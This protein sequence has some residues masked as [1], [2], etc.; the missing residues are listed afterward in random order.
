MAIDMNV[1][2][3]L[4]SARERGVCFRSTATIGRLNF[5]M[6]PE[7]LTELLLDFNCL[8]NQVTLKKLQ[9][10]CWSYAEPF[11]EFLGS[12]EV[13]S[14]D[15]SGYENATCVHDMN[16]PIAPEMKSRFDVVIDGGTLEHVFNFPVAIRNCMEMVKLGGHF[17]GVTTANNYCGHGFYQFSP[18]LFFR[19]FSSENGFVTER[20]LIS[21][22]HPNAT[23]FEAVD[24]DTVK[25]RV[26]FINDRPT[27]ILVQARRLAEK[28]VFRKPPQ[29][30]DYVSV[31]S[32]E[33]GAPVPV[34]PPLQWLRR[35]V[36]KFETA[37]PVATRITRPL[38]D[39]RRRRMSCWLGR[40][41]FLKPVPYSSGG[42]GKMPR[43][44]R[45]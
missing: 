39:Y 40:A 13:V 28:E 25:Q 16:Q 26:E 3:L 37:L 45:Q 18:E 44:P 33:N 7:L 29:Q 6:T 8:P 32:A 30:S 10:A 15:A 2:R 11:L 4:L 27:Y 5:S 36:S 22:V 14:I 23:W 17:L 12:E 35:F 24:P 20:V 42:C 21:E 38:I 34:A 1:A 31:W 9:S 43:L 41:D 19:V